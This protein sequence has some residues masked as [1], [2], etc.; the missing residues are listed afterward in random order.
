MWL[1]ERV[2]STDAIWLD[3]FTGSA[4]RELKGVYG[5]TPTGQLY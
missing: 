2:L 1:K 4:E 5:Y 3:E